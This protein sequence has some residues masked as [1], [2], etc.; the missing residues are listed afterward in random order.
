MVI[1]NDVD[2]LSQVLMVGAVSLTPSRVSS[3]SADRCSRVSEGARPRPLGARTSVGCPSIQ[4][5]ALSWGPPSSC[6]SS[7]MAIL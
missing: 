4:A 1:D 3:A 7:T 5:G 6:V 2:D